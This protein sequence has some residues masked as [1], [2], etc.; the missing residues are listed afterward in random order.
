MPAIQA[1]IDHQ[2]RRW[3]MERARRAE[4]PAGEVIRSPLKPVI[5]ISRQHGSG[6]SVIAGM[7]SRRFDYT[8]LHRDVIERIANSSGTRRRIIEALDAGAKSQIAMWCESMVSQRYMDTSDYVRYLHETIKS[9]AALGGAVVVGRGANFIV[10][11]DR[12]VHVRVVAPL[13]MRIE[14]LA[15]FAHLTRR[16]AARDVVTRDRERETFVRKT[17][18]RDIDDPLAYDLILNTASMTLEEAA[19]LIENAAHEK[20]ERLRGHAEHV[21]T[22]AK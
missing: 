12:G 21:E 17:Y 1:L 13:A 10:G 5:T 15:M 3:E 4:G 8:L 22:V 19:L 14:R 6:G 2:L 18:G 16:E 11:M 7:I 20:F 9:V